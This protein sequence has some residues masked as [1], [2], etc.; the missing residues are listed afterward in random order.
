[1]SLLSLSLLTSLTFCLLPSLN[2]HLPPFAPCP[3]PYVYCI[4]YLY[5]V[6]TRT[7][8]VFYLGSFP[9][10]SQPYLQHYAHHSPYRHGFYF[11]RI[12]PLCPCSLGLGG[13]QM[14]NREKTLARHPGLETMCVCVKPT[15]AFLTG[16]TWHMVAWA[17]F[18]PSSLLSL[19][20]SL[21]YLL[22]GHSRQPSACSMEELTATCI[23]CNNLMINLKSWNLLLYLSSSIPI[24][25]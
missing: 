9:Y 23:Y 11:A 17:D 7:V 3:L 6:L 12:S 22:A 5:I 19:S 15:G 24:F 1:M 25:M 18:S 21:S 13:W 4:P 2:L 14:V 20:L 16:K 8:S 10:H